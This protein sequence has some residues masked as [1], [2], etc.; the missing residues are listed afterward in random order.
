MKLLGLAGVL[1]L[2]PPFAF[3]ATA[4]AQNSCPAV[5]WCYSISELNDGKPLTGAF[6]T[7]QN[8]TLVAGDA[9]HMNTTIWLATKSDFSQWVET[10]LVLY[11]G[12]QYEAY[13]AD[14]DSGGNFHLQWTQGAAA[15]AS[16]HN[17]EIQQNS[18]TNWWNIYRDY[19]FVGTSTDQTSWQSCSVTGCME[20]GGEIGVGSGQLDTTQ[21]TGAFDLYMQ[22]KSLAGVWY[23]WPSHTYETDQ[24]CGPFAQGYC[25]NGYPYYAYEWSWNKP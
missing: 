24:S 11:S 20:A 14:V 10:G 18:H 23:Y 3:P 19:N 17:Y 12:G 16:E 6:G 5:Y 9:N 8:G 21:K 2:V 4:T 22:A 15:D 25:L 7:W 1:S 13:W